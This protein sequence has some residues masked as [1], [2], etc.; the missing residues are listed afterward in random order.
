[1]SITGGLFAG[2]S[3]IGANSVAFGAI[4]DN[5]SNQNTVG[6]KATDVR[7]K[8]LVTQQATL[9]SFSPGG[10]QTSPVQQV[11]VQGLLQATNNTTSMSVSGKGFFIVNDTVDPANTTLDKFVYTRAGDF[12]VDESG[13]LKNVGGFTLMAWPLDAN[14]NIASTINQSVV[15]DTIPVNLNDIGGVAN[16]T[17]N[18]EL[19]LNLPATATTGDT[20]Q[21]TTRIFDSLGV[22]H[23]VDVVFTKQA[24]SGTSEADITGTLDTGAAVAS[25]ATQ[26]FTLVDGQGTSHT[27]TVTLEKLT[28]AG[29]DDTWDVQS[30]TFPGGTAT[31]NSGSTNSIT[32][33]TNATTDT[34]DF[35][36][37]FTSS[38]AGDQTVTLDFS[39][40]TLAGANATAATVTNDQFGTWALT[41]STTGATAT[42]GGT[43][44]LTFNRNGTLNSPANFDLTL[45]Y[46]S[47]NAETQTVTYDLGTSGST[48]GLTQFA[49]QFTPNFIN[50]DGATTGFFESVTID[51]S[52]VVTALFDNG[53]TQPVYQIPLVTFP[54]PNGLSSITGNAYEE[55]DFS[56]PV[57]VRTAGSGGAGEIAASALEQ[58]TVDLAEEFTKMIVTQ[59]AFS[60]NAR[61]ITTGD[62]MLEELIRLKR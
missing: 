27:V 11:D 52:G 29:T 6:F 33:A 4:A 13:F 48:D 46:T 20:E 40:L 59:R 8:T 36:F 18:V 62:E 50:Q 38:G 35:D 10:V 37:D 56:G 49:S 1:M 9:T 3:G 39:G 14:G 32:F 55:T 2:V 42:A 17:A 16:A 58:S 57:T 5:I 7:F 22:Q 53:V 26:A 60:A 24:D 12:V 15:D 34:I 47:P 45:D 19:G 43:Q 21:I 61:S 54:N 23:D 31:L 51:N 30:V 25:T 28:E 44:T 41:A